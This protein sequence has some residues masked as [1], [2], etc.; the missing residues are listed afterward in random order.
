MK[1]LK[2]D[3]RKS[4]NGNLAAVILGIDG[5]ITEYESRIKDGSLDRFSPEAELYI[6]MSKISGVIK[7]A[8]K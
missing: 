1:D 3:N 8:I 2:Y 5:K 4:A 7:K 6:F